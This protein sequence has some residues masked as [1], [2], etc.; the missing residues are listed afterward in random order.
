MGRRERIEEEFELG[1][2]QEAVRE[3]EALTE[4]FL[5][6]TA[7]LIAD[8]V[9]QLVQG[10]AGFGVDLGAGPGNLVKE[11]ATR[12]PHVFMIGLDISLPMAQ[13]GRE[14]ARAEGMGNVAFVVADVH[15]LPFKSRSLGV[16][17]SHG[18]MHHWRRLDIALSEVKQVLAENG[19][20]YISDLRRDAPQAVVKRI[21]DLLSERQ[22]RAFLH[23][24]RAAYTMEELS[25]LVQEAGLAH[26][27]VEPENF[28][29]RTIMRNM[30]ELRRSP[31]RGI[32][33]V[34]L[35]LRLVGGGG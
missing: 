9:V 5:A 24:V 16:I 27:R 13:R 23:S 10:R 35:N 29:R 18:S 25:T 7:S 19:F 8:E 3:Y 31:M 14:R 33:Q 28:S 30:Q 21:I 4:S 6:I 17:V 22:A 34:S 15:R 12:L 20:I 11:M 26:I 2:E 32:R 1:E